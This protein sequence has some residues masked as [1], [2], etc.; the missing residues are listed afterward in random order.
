M[1]N[2]AVIPVSQTA[3]PISVDGIIDSL[4]AAG[5]G[6]RAERRKRPRC[7]VGT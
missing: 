4:D 1:K 3:V 6:A 5:Q 2:G 7:A